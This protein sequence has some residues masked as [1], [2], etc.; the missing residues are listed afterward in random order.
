M[1][2]DEVRHPRYRL[3]EALRRKLRPFR[4]DR[5]SRRYEEENSLQLQYGF[6]CF[7]RSFLLMSHSVSLLQ[8]EYAWEVQ[9]LPGDFISL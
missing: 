6:V 4:R 7:T 2:I 8:F 9:V 5:R 3:G 1:A